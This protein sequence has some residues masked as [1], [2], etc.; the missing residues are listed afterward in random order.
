MQKDKKRRGLDRLCW[1]L[2]KN[3]LI[4]LMIILCITGWFFY[5]ALQMKSGV[6]LAEMF[7]YNHP[8]LKLN[9]QFSKVFGSGSSGVVI[10]LKSKQGDIFTQAFLGKI[11]AM[12]QE[13]EMMDGVYR[14]LTR[15]IA[16][17]SAK[18]VSARAGGEISVEPLIYYKIPE[19]AEEMELLKKRIFTSPSFNGAM[20][21]QDGTAA[22]V[23]TEF[24]ENISYEKVHHILQKLVKDYSDNQTSVH[25]VGFPSLMGWIYS[26]KP[27]ML[28][29]FLISIVG[30]IVVLILIFY[31]NPLGMIVVTANTLILTLWGLGF[32]GFTGINFNPMLLV[33][34]FLVGARIVGNSHQITYR[35]FEE[36]HASKG[37]RFLASYETMRTM[38][39]PNFVSV[40]TDTAGFAVLF[41]AKIILMLNLSIIMSF[42]MISI[43]LT[44]FLV[45][46]ICSLI[47]LKV[48]SDKFAKD[49]CQVDSM[50]RVMMWITRFS[51]GRGGR[52]VVGGFIAVLAIFC[53][54][55][56]SQLKIGDP[57]PG[58]PLFYQSHQYNQDQ[59]LI[60]E[61]FKAS[62]ENLTLFYQGEPNS[63]YDPVVFKT[64]EQFGRYMQANL[65]DIYKSASSLNNMI[66]SVNYTWHD[67]D[68]AW[69]QLPRQEEIL[70]FCLGNI[71]TAGF[72]FLNRFTSPGREK[73]QTTLFFADHTS[74]NLLRIRDAAYSF[75]ESYPM[76]IDKG[77]FL[78]A[79]G[80]IGM[81]IAV[82]EEMKKSHIIIDLT[83]LAAIF[84]LCTLSFRSIV[85]GLMLCLPLLIGNSVAGAYM[86]LSGIGLSINTL[87]VAAIGVGVGID[88]AIYLY[89]RCQEEFHAQGSDWYN[90]IIQSVCTCGKAVVFTGLTIILPI[91][92]WYLFSDMK[93]QAQVGFFL[94]M[95]MGTNVV[96]TLTLHPL[97]IYIIKPK[98][99]TKR[100][101]LEARN[102][103]AGKLA[104]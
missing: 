36:L 97:L 27:Q 6:I 14:D 44:G 19:T 21:A 45:P 31:G 15:S 1:F 71:K 25:I 51:V 58:S 39:I 95:I 47:P 89:S 66:K 98:F 100:G 75:F 80:R 57:T 50:A 33:L 72:S 9:F 101:G 53:F 40:A 93:F 34:A 61:K 3:R 18:T 65:P 91:I 17:L 56:T 79:G 7:P 42:W 5:G 32:V 73:A 41:I 84:I 24:H 74:D 103:L 20:V 35:Y 54:W 77:E 83:V 86:A 104:A 30:M 82:N 43:I 102:T 78:L 64:F 76:K 49:S 48:A 52:Y 59:A 37:D 23:F 12:T 2:A 62:S 38:F 99:I 60:N 85:A 88:F 26:L 8:Y 16:S 28:S 67:G 70:T 46:A 90:T 92:S 94:A 4:V 96:L 63:V 29:V 81:E 55:Q 22:L 68:E 13:V 10:C 87:P 69:N 11:K